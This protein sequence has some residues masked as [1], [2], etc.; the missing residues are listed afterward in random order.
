MIIWHHTGTA[1]ESSCWKP[2]AAPSPKRHRRSA[3]NPNIAKSLSFLLDG[4]PIIIVTKGTARVDNR[5]YKATFHSKASMI[6]FG[7]VDAYIGH[8]PGGV[9]PFGIKDGVRVYL[10]RSLCE[11]DTVYPAGGDDH[12]AV[13]LTPDELYDVSGA[14]EWVDVCKE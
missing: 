8:E 3:R 2:P 9:C 4:Q 14:D 11:F 12:S 7:E 13:K 1:T 5:K 6:P 10:D